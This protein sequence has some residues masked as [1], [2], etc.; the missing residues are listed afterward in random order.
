MRGTPIKLKKQANERRSA[1]ARL[2]LLPNAE[3]FANIYRVKIALR[4]VVVDKAAIDKAFFYEGC[5]IELFAG[6]HELR[7]G[8]GAS[9]IE[10]DCRELK[11]VELVAVAPAFGTKVA[12]FAPAPLA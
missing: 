2:S 3:N 1:A 8:D 12:K 10:L 4:V 9:P 11:M 6:E 7:F 5:R